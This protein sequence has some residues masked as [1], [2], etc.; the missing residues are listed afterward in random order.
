MISHGIMALH[1]GGECLAVAARRKT[2]LRPGALLRRRSTVTQ[3]DRLL[4]HEAVHKCGRNSV[5]QAGLRRRGIMWP[6]RIDVM[7]VVERPYTTLARLARA[8][9]LAGIRRDAICARI[10]TK[11]I[12]K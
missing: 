6:A 2:A 11:I 10:G 5:I 8:Q 1:T 9:R 7:H 12:V 4:I 3:T